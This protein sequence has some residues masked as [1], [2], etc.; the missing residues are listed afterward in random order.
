[1]S[2]T[3]DPAEKVVVYLQNKG[4]SAEEMEDILSLAEDVHTVRVQRLSTTDPDL[5]IDVKNVNFILKMKKH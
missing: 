4:Y 3:F 1:M 2:D 5:Y